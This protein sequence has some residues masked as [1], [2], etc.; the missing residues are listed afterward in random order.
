MASPELQQ[1]VD[2]LNAQGLVRTPDPAQVQAKVQAYLLARG[3]SIAADPGLDLD[4]DHVQDQDLVELGRLDVIAQYPTLPP[5]LATTLE[6]IAAE[7]DGTWTMDGDISD[8]DT[9]PDR[10][11]TDKSRISVP[12]SEDGIDQGRGGL[13]RRAGRG[14]RGRKRSILDEAMDDEQFPDDD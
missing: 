13:Q 2:K 9:S 11:T 5:N 3:R 7:R 14:T 12:V 4:L 1:M 8:P 10:S 6:M